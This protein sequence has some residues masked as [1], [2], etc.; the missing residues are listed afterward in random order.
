MNGQEKD[1]TSS[2]LQVNLERT[3]ARVEIPG[4]YGELLKVAEPHY[5]VQKRTRELLVELNH[6]YVNWDY[7]LTQ[8][9]TL[10][11][12]DFH[13]FNGHPDG[14]AALTTILGIYVSILRSAL[15]ETR[16]K[17]LRC[18]F[19]F[20]DTVIAK[21]NRFISRNIPLFARA[22]DALLE[23]IGRPPRRPGKAP[24]LSRIS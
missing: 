5:G 14:L 4:E 16:E 11:I 21:S 19:D 17:A 10:S 20:L 9:K 18:L 6:P 1:F 2:A 23:F 13:D 24:P 3:A 12:G 15:G 7:V 22:I 8:L